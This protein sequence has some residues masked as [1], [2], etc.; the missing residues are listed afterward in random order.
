MRGEDTGARV[1]QVPVLDVATVRKGAGLSQE[2]FAQRFRIPLGTLRNWEQ[3]VRQPE[4]PA[5]VLLM[6]IAAEPAA[7]DRALRAWKPVEIDPARI[8]P[9][10]PA[11]AKAARVKAAVRRKRP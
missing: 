10:A 2:Q 11:R 5:R 9:K 4:G 7:V 3:G 8:R 1:W 6:V